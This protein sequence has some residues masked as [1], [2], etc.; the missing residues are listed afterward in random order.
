M[1][2]SEK[3]LRIRDNPVGGGGSADVRTTLFPITFLT[4]QG[5]VVEIFLVHDPCHGR[6]TC[7]PMDYMRPAALPLF[8]LWGDSLFAAFRAAIIHA[9]ILNDLYLRR[10]GL[11]FPAYESRSDCFHRGAADT[12][13]MPLFWYIKKYPISWQAL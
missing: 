8:N 5:H 11:Q 12:S 3:I 4:V 9:V 2:G 1:H 13:D 10:N 6:R 7:Y